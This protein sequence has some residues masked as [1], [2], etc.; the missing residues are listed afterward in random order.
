MRKIFHL[1]SMAVLVAAIGCNRGTQNGTEEALKVMSFNIRMSDGSEQTDGDNHWQHRKEAVVEMLQAEHPAVIGM[2]EVCWEQM[3]YL[4]E[5]LTGYAGLGVGRDDG[6]EAGEVMAIFYDEAV[7]EA[8]VWGTFWLSETPGEVSRGWDAACHRT[9]T[10]A[11][12][13]NRLSGQ[14]WAMINTHLDHKGPEARREG[15]RLIANRV[16]ALKAQGLPVVITADF[17]AT[18]DEEIFA[19][20]YAAADDARK[21]AKESDESDTFNG[22]GRSHSQIDHIFCSGYEVERFAVLT[23]DYGVPYISDHYPVV[24]ELR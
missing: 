8:T 13:R 11:I 19:P 12:F 7:L 10:W 24:A 4:Q 6:V 2:Q 5:H 21:V 16:E 20:L 22:W 9:A 1:L 17:N 3:V 14:T 18:T 23:D 15:M